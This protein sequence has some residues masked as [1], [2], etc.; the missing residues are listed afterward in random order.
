M[1][2]LEKKRGGVRKVVFFCFEI[3]QGQRVFGLS[4]IDY[5]TKEK[6]K[7]LGAR[8]GFLFDYILLVSVDL[9]I[10]PIRV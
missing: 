5:I 4:P 3:E 8:C 6:S 2:D 10:N 9:L 7:S 1:L